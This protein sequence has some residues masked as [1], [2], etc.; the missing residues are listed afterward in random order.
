[1]KARGNH[2]L[3]AS[4]TTITTG[5]LRA[6]L[7][8]PPGHSRETPTVAPRGEVDLGVETQ[9]PVPMVTL[10]RSG[11]G[12]SHQRMLHHRL[13]GGVGSVGDLEAV[14]PPLLTKV[15]GEGIVRCL[16]EVPAPI[17]PLPLPPLVGSWS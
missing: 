17:S 4:R 3:Q 10:G 1:V 16:G 11:L 14:H 8:N 9:L 13:V 12:L 5:D 15:T 6:A 7:C 2:P